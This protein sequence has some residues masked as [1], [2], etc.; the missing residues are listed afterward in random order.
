[1]HHVFQ[2]DIGSIETAERALNLA[3]QFIDRHWS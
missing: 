3:A 1:M 2:R